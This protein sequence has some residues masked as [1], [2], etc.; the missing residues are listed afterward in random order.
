[1]LQL[2]SIPQYSNVLDSYVV[3]DTT[4]IFNTKTN[5]VIKNY[6]YSNGQLTRRLALQVKDGGVHSFS[7]DKFRKIVRLYL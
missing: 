3:I 7:A 4:T 2:S 1:M 5:K 6:D